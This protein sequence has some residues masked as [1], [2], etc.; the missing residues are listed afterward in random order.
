MKR[1]LVA[2]LAILLLGGCGSEVT[3]PAPEAPVAAN[4]GATTSLPDW[5]EVPSIAAKSSLVPL[6]LNPDKT[7]EVP[8]VDKPLQAGWYEN[9]PPPGQAG[10]AVVLGHIDGNH[11][12]GIF[13]RLRDVKAGDKVFVGTKDGKKLGF[14]VSKV[15]QVAKSAF[16][17]DAVYGDTADPELR[18]I[19]CGG[20]FDHETGNYRDNI[21]VY[22]KLAS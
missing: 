19:T 10:P 8:P 12:K 18:L 3:A 22:A 9:S 16:P 11:Q 6:G 14:T 1:W 15:D 17:T 4:A 7:V 2:L 5:V 20:V 21:I 13:W